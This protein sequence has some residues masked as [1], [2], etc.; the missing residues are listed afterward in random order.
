MDSGA[1]ATNGS[2]DPVARLAGYLRELSPLL[3]PASGWYAEFLRRDPEGVRACLTG[4][5][6]PPVDVLDS[7]MQDLAA[8]RG[9]HRA[10]HETA[11]L[12]G[13]RA[14]AVRTHDRRPGGHEEL[15]AVL[16]MARAQRGT[17]LATLRDLR[18]R[19]PGPH[20]DAEL[21][22]TRDDLARAESRCTDLTSRL[23][24]LS[25]P[26]GPPAPAAPSTRPTA[27]GSGPISDPGP[28]PEPGSGRWAPVPAR[29]RA[30]GGTGRR[31][32]GWRLGGARHA[33]APPA[34]PGSPAQ[35]LPGRT[36]PAPAPRGA[37]Y[38]PPPTPEAPPGRPHPAPTPAPDPAAG[39]VGVAGT[40]AA[41]IGLRAQHRSGEAH[42]LLCEAAAGPPEL[43]PE[44]AAELTRAG[45]SAD[46]A[47]LLWEAAS[48]PPARLAAAAAA[49][50]IAGR[51]ADCGQL[52]R[53]G[54]ARPAAEIADAA[55]ALWDAGRD[56]EA[57]ALLG[58][59][60][61]VRSAEESARVARHDPRRLAPRLLQAARSISEARHRDLLHAL[62]VAGLPTQ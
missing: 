47:T 10:A 25:A 46:W 62:R 2:A 44:L 36:D 40:V 35:P 60:V 50:G 56:Q 8:L 58:A 43:L 39:P 42:A 1:E 22:W 12:A 13:L 20:L 27:G 33:G 57:G 21:S 53:Q 7:L 24:A 55:L 41:L 3:D 54:V 16:A 11:V 38:A 31:L 32:P 49:L 51:A 26:T 52:L 15:T 37:R 18:G 9:P 30:I 34:D 5:A 4:A 19:A 59:F 28:V 23:D 29:Q 6:I 14:E 48:L 17:A 61:R 45:L